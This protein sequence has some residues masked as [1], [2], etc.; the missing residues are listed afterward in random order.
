MTRTPAERPRLSIVIPAYNEGRAVVPV[1]EGLLASLAKLDC[2]TE[3]VVVE[4]GSTD[5]TAQKVREPRPARW[6]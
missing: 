6:V 1:L 3:I 5:D 4:D 2:A